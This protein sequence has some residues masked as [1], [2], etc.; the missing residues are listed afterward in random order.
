MKSSNPERLLSF[1]EGMI[2]GAVWS[3]GS[4]GWIA[5][6]AL[7]GTWINDGLAPALF[8]FGLVFLLGAVAFAMAL[9]VSLVCEILN[10]TTRKS[11]RDAFQYF[12]WVFLYNILIGGFAVWL[13]MAFGQRP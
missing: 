12:G 5:A 6:I 2:F 13:A 7:I 1:R 9:A 3:C 11:R 10:V 8:W 4:V